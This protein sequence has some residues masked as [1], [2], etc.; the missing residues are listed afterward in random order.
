MVRKLGNFLL[1]ILV[2]DVGSRMSACTCGTNLMEDLG[3]FHT[4]DIHENGVEEDMEYND[5]DMHCA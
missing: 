3:A 4:V 2:S 5:G 1:T